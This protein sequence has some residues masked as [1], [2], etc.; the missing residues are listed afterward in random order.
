MLERLIE[1]NKVVNV[2]IA[3][4]NC[5]IEGLTNAEFKF[6]QQLI[7]LLGP[8]ELATVQLS[9]M[10]IFYKSNMALNILI[11]KEINTVLVRLYY[12]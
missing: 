10:W 9:G 12:Q 2:F 7:K 4:N 5:D 6:G 3:E 1:Q 11:L 8:L